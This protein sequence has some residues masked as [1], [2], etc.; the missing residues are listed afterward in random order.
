MELE[1]EKID[2]YQ[3]PEISLWSEEHDVA[4]A[5]STREIQLIPTYLDMSN[6]ENLIHLFSR[7]LIPVLMPTPLESTFLKRSKAIFQVFDNDTGNRILEDEGDGTFHI[8]LLERHST[9]TLKFECK[10]FR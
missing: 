5:N 1:L 10:T 3:P 4:I 2:V 9:Q 7:F 8:P 6:M